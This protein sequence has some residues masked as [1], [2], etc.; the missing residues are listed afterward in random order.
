M[1]KRTDKQILNDLK[2]MYNRKVNRLN[3]A[4]PESFTAFLE[5]AKTY[6]QEAGVSLKEAVRKRLNSITYTSYEER[7]HK[8]AIDT[9]KSEGMYSRLYRM[10]GK[11]SFSASSYNDKKLYRKIGNDDYHASGSYMMGTVRVIYWTSDDGSQDQYIEFIP[12]TGNSWLQKRQGQ[13]Y[14]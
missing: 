13:A 5:K 14:A 1:R 9:L 3:R 11:T 6:S 12:M 2:M 8:N 4:A 7:T 10:G